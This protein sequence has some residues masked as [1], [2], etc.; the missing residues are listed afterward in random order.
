MKVE[1]AIVGAGPAGLAAAAAATRHGVET[2]LFDRRDRAGGQYYARPAGA[3]WL[4]GL[5]AETFRG[6]R[7]EYLDVRLE[8]DVWGAFPDRTLAFSPAEGTE[9]TLLRADAVLVATGA[10]ERPQPFNGWDTPGVVSAGGAQLLLKESAVVPNGTVVV[11]G[12][13][14]FL[15]AVAAQLAAAGATVGALVEARSRSELARLAPALV[16]ERTLWGETARILRM[17]S[18]LQQH[19]G[20]TIRRV[21]PGELVLSTGERIPFDT[22]CVGHGFTPR[23]EL[24]SQLGCAASR[25]GIQVSS[26]L[27]TS[28]P[29]IFVAGETS[30]I[31]GARLALAEGQLAGLVVSDRLR[32][33]SVSARELDRARARRA[34]LRSFARRLFRVYRPLEPLALADADTT[35]CR[36]ED[37]KLA[38]IASVA[39]LPTVDSTRALKAWLRCGMGACQGAMCGEALRA[40]LGRPDEDGWSR[41]AARPP[42]GA[43]SL[44]AVARLRFPS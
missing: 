34:R 12:T 35:I 20:A 8:S 42:A 19:F 28:L 33:G 11:A 36:C 26:D 30:G 29:E 4:D 27:E 1:L 9:S 41:P 17:T 3:D 43:V 32:P 37:V 15:L 39:A 24:L 23:V 25:E 38:D 16:R 2:A 13:G 21:L 18:R 22:L 14:P 31:G 7:P 40:A 44:S 10:I 6:L 5:P